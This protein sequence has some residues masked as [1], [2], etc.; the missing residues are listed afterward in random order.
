MENELKEMLF[1]EEMRNAHQQG[2]AIGY[3]DGLMVRF[4]TGW[5]SRLVG[6]I[7]WK[8]IKDKMILTGLTNFILKS[9]PSKKSDLAKLESINWKLFWNVWILFKPFSIPR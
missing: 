6:R 3:I 9:A 5:K 4:E 8:V 1:A 2:P 7:L